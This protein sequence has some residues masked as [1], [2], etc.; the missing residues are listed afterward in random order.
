[1]GECKSKNTHYS[2][3]ESSMAARLEDSTANVVRRGR[4]S[5]FERLGTRCMVRYRSYDRI[6]RKDPN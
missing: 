2:T 1:M 5:D 4:L 6:G 3:R